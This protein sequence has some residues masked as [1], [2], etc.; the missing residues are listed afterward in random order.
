M[1]TT[2]QQAFRPLFI[3]CFIIGL[4]VYPLNSPKSRIVY[5]S[6]LYSAIV[7]FVYGYL[8]YC[9]VSS[10]SLEALFPHTITLILLEVNIIATITSVI[11]NIYYNKRIQMCMERLT[12]VDDT[13]K[14]LGSPKIYRKMHM[15]SKRIAIGWTVFSFALNFDDTIPWLLQLKEKTI[16]WRF[17]VPHMYNYCIHTGA[18]VNLVFITFL[19]YIG[20]RFDEV[21]QHMQNLLIKKKKHSL[22]N[23][24]KKPIIIVHQRTLGTDNYKRVLWSSIHLHL[25]LCRIAREWNLVFGIQMAAETASYPLFGT[26][27]CFYI[28]K[29][30]THKYRNL[31]PVSVWFRVISWTFMFVG[32]V[33]IINHICENANKIDKIINE[34]TLRYA[35]VLKEIYQFNL[36]TMHHPLEFTGMGFF[37]F[38]NKFFIKFCVAITTFLIIVIQMSNA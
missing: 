34:L 2:V 20:T 32:K 21:N 11:F 16:S 9:M 24:W 17:I 22:R 28:Y 7:W 4:C 33:Y 13:L 25:E 38:G 10:I 30:L 26:S 15:L 14:E 18:L 36:Q 29:L 23:T 27:M 6:V 12:T 5:L 31:I 3:T 1:T 8:L 37:P 35:D 19:W